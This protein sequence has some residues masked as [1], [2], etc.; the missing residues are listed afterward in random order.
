MSW[1]PALEVALGR[2]NTIV[3]AD[4]IGNQI[5]WIHNVRYWRARAV[6]GP[7]PATGALQPR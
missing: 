4:V 1:A 5:G 6:T 3:I 2:H 7:A